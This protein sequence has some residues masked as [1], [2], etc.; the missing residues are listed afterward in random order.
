MT[1]INEVPT[2]YGGTDGSITRYWKGANNSN[3]TTDVSDTFYTDGDTKS[4]EFVVNVR[5]DG[6]SLVINVPLSE[7]GNGNT[8]KRPY[9]N[10]LLLCLNGTTES[11]EDLKIG[12]RPNH[13][14]NIC[15]LDSSSNDEEAIIRCERFLDEDPN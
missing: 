2:Q 9:I 8:L 11:Y 13:F 1:S 6:E 10:D 4:D 3:G 14:K 7:D 5:K 15:F 12:K